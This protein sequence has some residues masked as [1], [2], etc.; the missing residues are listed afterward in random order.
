MI[1]AESM[2]K[3]DIEDLAEQYCSDCCLCCD[4]CGLDDFVRNLYYEIEKYNTAERER[5]DIT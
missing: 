1:N 2:T 4:E 5:N 3:D